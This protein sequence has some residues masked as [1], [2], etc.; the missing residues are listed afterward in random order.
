[1]DLVKHG[2][3]S[4]EIKEEMEKIGL[5]DT[6][7][8]NAMLYDDDGHG[9]EEIIDLMGALAQ[10]ELVSTLS[11]F[12][13]DYLEGHED[14]MDAL[15]NAVVLDL[16]TNSLAVEDHDNDSRLLVSEKFI[17]VTS[18]TCESHGHKTLTSR[19]DCSKAAA[20]LGRTVTWG[21]HGGYQDV[22]T[23]CSARFST[24]STHL[25]FN[26]P[27]VCDPGASVGHW[28]YTGCECTS[29]MP[30]LCEASAGSCMPKEVTKANPPKNRRKGP[31]FRIRNDTKWPVEFSLWQVRHLS[32]M[33]LFLCLLCYCG[34]N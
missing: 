5:G 8:Q 28:T 11:T 27:D 19:D 2:K 12:N 24:S 16:S 23:G 21:P 10:E 32:N 30:C 17:E 29:W 7:I 6:E 1:M 25:F 26:N 20:Q 22:V 31:G 33:Y 18:G 9:Q 13:E 14:S 34:D 4:T 15:G 3:G